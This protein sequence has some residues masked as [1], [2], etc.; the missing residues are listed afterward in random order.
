MK[1]SERCNQFVDQR[2]IEILQEDPQVCFEGVVPECEGGVAV[3]LQRRRD[4]LTSAVWEY[5]D[6][7]TEAICKYRCDL[8]FDPIS[9]PP[10]DPNCPDW[11]IWQF[12]GELA[13]T[14]VEGRKRDG[15]RD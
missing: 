6:K 13:E 1:P 3:Q 9:K 10:L 12:K 14:F 8:R 4:V 5:A 11:E 7:A 2:V 15:Y